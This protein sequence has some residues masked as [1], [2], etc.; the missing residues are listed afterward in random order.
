MIC[1]SVWN[2]IKCYSNLDE[3]RALSY[4]NVSLLNVPRPKM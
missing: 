1:S 4:R 3:C 2:Y